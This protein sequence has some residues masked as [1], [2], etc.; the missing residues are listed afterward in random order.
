M[1][2]TYPIHHPSAS[3]PNGKGQAQW[4]FL[5][6]CLF[7]LGVLLLTGCGSQSSNSATIH[8]ANGSPTT[9]LAGAL[10]MLHMINADIGW[11]EVMN[12]S[13]SSISFTVIRTTDGGNHWQT[14][15]QCS[16]YQ[17]VGKGAGFATCPGDFR[18]ATL[19]TVVE[20]QQSTLNIYH[21]VDGGQTWQ[22]S[23]L[24][25]GYLETPP[26]F[27]DALHGW[28]LVTDN[29]PGFDPG[30]TYIGKEIA[31]LRTV[32]GGHS[33]QKIGSS[34]ATSQLP[35][36]S[37]DAY[38]TAPFTASTRMEFTSSTD[39]WLVGTSYRKDN[40]SFSW[41]YVTHD[42]GTNWSKVALSF[43]AQSDALWTP[44]FFT[45]Q[46]GLLT[47]STSGPAPTYTPETMLYATHDGGATWTGTFIPFDVTYAT[48]LDMT[49]A[50]LWTG[51]LKQYTFS[52]TSDGWRHWTKEN[53]S[54]SFANIY[55]FDFVSPTLGWALADNVQFRRPEPGGGLSPGDTIALLKTTDGGHTWQEV[56]RSTV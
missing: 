51:S 28:V 36:T 46:D 27:I 35:V 17:G 22:R 19:A 31:L 33:W 50:W 48:Y 39:G 7:L 16:P 5:S 25:A 11:A 52:I 2:S 45:A 30:S 37:D 3:I 12:L 6:F 18:S 38:G 23:T 42:G 40:S 8:G 15:L 44:Q 55:S 14:V 13:S 56:A 43:P 26:V 41:L 10:D 49:H 34:A 54:T 29:Y 24:N 4:Y 20:T 32:D 9:K 1:Y 47:V 21:T 53:L